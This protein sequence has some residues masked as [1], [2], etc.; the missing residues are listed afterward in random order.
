M[1][2]PLPLNA[3]ESE[4]DSVMVRNYKTYKKIFYTI[5]STGIKI[6]F[7][8]ETSD[9]AI[10]NLRFRHWLTKNY[11]GYSLKP[12]GDWD[13]KL[14]Y[15]DFTLFTSSSINV[16]S[17]SIKPDFRAFQPERKIFFWKR[18]NFLPDKNFEVFYRCK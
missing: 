3:K 18:D 8:F 13:V 10:L 2:F 14:R 11:F 12:I 15:A 1:L 7:D 6:N 5:D 16:D 9:T 17:L 4:I